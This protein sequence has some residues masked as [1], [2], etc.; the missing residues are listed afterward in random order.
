MVTAFV[1][2]P[3]NN[4]STHMDEERGSIEGNVCNN[5]LRFKRTASACVRM[6]A[7]FFGAYRLSLSSRS[8][9]DKRSLGL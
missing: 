2:H 5:A 7:Y 3:I 6:R 4:A 9:A 8:P 1:R